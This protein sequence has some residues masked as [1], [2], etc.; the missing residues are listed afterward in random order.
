MIKKF[1]IFAII[2][3]ALAYWFYPSPPTPELSSQPADIVIS[4]VFDPAK[5]KSKEVWRQVLTKEQFYILQ[6]A[7]TEI[8][9][10][11]ELN[12]EKRPGTY[13]S[14]GCDVP[15]FRSEMKYY[16]VTGWPSFTAP[17][18]TSSVV[19]R[20]EGVGDDRI[21]VLDPCGGHLGHV[22]DDG[23]KPTGKRYCMNSVALRFIP[24]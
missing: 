9:Y 19:L 22:F 8:P 6:E 2:A 20:R 24:D 14:Q 23:P 13:Y 4:G 5:L 1:A 21:E 17:I 10:T 3:V 16:S 18:N 7:G 11:G 12:G 15:L